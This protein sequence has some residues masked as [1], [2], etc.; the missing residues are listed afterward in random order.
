MKRL[1][2]RRSAEEARRAN[3]DFVHRIERNLVVGVIFSTVFFVSA[4]TSV[5]DMGQSL[6]S[7][8]GEQPSSTVEL[9]ITSIVM[10]IVLNM[11]FVGAASGIDLLRP[12][13]AR[14]AKD[15]G[16]QAERLQ[17]LIEHKERLVAA[18]ASAGLFARVAMVIVAFPVTEA[19][20]AAL[21][22]AGHAPDGSTL[23]ISATIVAVPIVLVQMFAGDA[24]PKA[25][26]GVH[27]HRVAL[28]LYRLVRIS[29]AL[30]APF[31][32]S[33][34]WLSQALAKRFGANPS[35]TQ[36][37][38][39]EEEIKNLVES[40]QET[41]EIEVDEK[42]LL[43]SVFEFTDTVAREIMTPRVDVDAMPVRSNPADVIRVIQDSGHSR[44]PLY[45][46]TDDQIVGIIHAKD[47]LTAV[48]ASPDAPVSLRRLMRPAL[49]VP[50]N[51]NLH[52]LLREMRTMKNQL[53]VVQDEFGGTAGIV[54][55]ED[56]VEELVGDIVDEYDNEEPEVVSTASGFLVEG[57]AHLDDVNEQVGSDFES[58]D[59]D[60]IGG[61][62]FGLF[63][64]QPDVG[65]SISVEGHRFV[66]V[67]TDGRRI[68]KMR[69][70]PADAES[71]AQEAAV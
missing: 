66:I 23:G 6:S 58:E 44:I 39:A 15:G 55:I 57:K 9:E 34:L 14:S 60:T 54:T 24:I 11:L 20:N 12:I 51:K 35:L 64:R 2:S 45:E 56:I 29:D 67:D 19:L 50:E 68:L 27:P 36:V 53:A 65:E 31:S 69:I 41:G 33:T 8:V 40:A 46:D 17:F 30:M 43:H 25:Y 59:F 71:E 52:E 5:G 26:A 3:A 49:F 70:E 4:V 62:V 16:V 13:H 48:I 28:A 18:C 1:T 47:L 63:G 22:K 42:E 38:Q 10:L 61:Y 7:V 21:V 32:M 37:N